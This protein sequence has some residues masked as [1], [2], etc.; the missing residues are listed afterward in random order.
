M[1][2]GLAKRFAA[3]SWN[4][5]GLRDGRVQGGWMGHECGA[6]PKPGKR[7]WA[8]LRQT[9]LQFHWVTARSVYTGGP[10]GHGACGDCRSSIRALTMRRGIISFVPAICVIFDIA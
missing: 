9:R 2:L 1:W 3:Y 7:D 10:H 5:I 6:Q 4:A 8:W